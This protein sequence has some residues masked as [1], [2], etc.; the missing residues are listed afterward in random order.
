MGV[1]VAA[2]LAGEPQILLEM[3]GCPPHPGG[4]GMGLIPERQEPAQ[5]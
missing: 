5:K 4:G 1:L 2:A 3:A